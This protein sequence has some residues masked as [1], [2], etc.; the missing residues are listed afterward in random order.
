MSQSKLDTNRVVQLLLRDSLPTLG[1]RARAEVLRLASNY[2]ALAGE[3]ME[4]G[5]SLSDAQ[6]ALD[7]AVV[8]GLQEAAHDL[9]WDTTWPACPVHPRHP[10]WYD[11]I[12]RAWCCKQ[13]P[14][15]V[16]PLGCLADLH[17]PAT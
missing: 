15:V 10:L 14:A 12:R 3:W 6:R 16:A 9:F 8:D 11:E 5:Q 1:E 2:E 7:A 17:P 13:D 4:D